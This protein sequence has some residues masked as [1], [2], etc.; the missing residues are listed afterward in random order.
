M[1]VMT[2]TDT[3]TVVRPDCNRAPVVGYS[4]LKG[5]E[6]KNA[7]WFEEYTDSTGYELWYMEDTTSIPVAPF[8]IYP[9]PNDGNFTISTGNNNFRGRYRIC[10]VVGREIYF[11]DIQ[12]PRAII[13]MPAVATGVYM[14]VLQDISGGR[15]NG[16]IR[17]YKLL[18]R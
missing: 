18:V 1:Y 9:N 14:L 16:T 15:S 3:A 13:Q 7:F 5:I 11:G 17:T 10:D 2:S 6:Y 12:G 8:A 4:V